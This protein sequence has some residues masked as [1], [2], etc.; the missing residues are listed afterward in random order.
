MKYYLTKYN[1]NNLYGLALL[2]DNDKY[3]FDNLNK[4][5]FPL[6]NKENTFNTKEEFISKYE[7][8]EITEEESILLNILLGKFYGN[9]YYPE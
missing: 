7:W 8:I 5:I 2:N 9:F 3:Y 4:N 6:S 1:N